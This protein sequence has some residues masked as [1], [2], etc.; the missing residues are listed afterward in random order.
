MSKC[1]DRRLERLVKEALY[2]LEDPAAGFVFDDFDLRYRESERLREK[3]SAEWFYRDK[4][5]FETKYDED[6]NR[7]DCLEPAWVSDG[8]RGAFETETIVSYLLDGEE[9]RFWLRLWRQRRLKLKSR[10][11]A[12]HDALAVDWRTAVAAR[13]A[14]SSR[15]TVDLCKKIFKVHFAQCLQAWARDSG[16]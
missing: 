6:C 3:K 4:T 16:V 5:P 2:A 9:D 13:I 10:H 14:G 15:P 7:N 11:R 8:G 12:I 1:S